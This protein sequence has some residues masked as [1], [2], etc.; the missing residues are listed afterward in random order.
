MLPDEPTGRCVRDGPK[1]RVDDFGVTLEGYWLEDYPPLQE[2][3]C[4]LP[5]RMFLQVNEIK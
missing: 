5:K 3:S 4:G 1:A 2:K